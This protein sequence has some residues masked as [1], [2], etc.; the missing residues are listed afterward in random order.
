M[1][2]KTA[3]LLALAIALTIGSV[4][5]AQ[6]PSLTFTG[7]VMSVDTQ[8]HTFT[9]DT[10]KMTFTTNDQT[11]YTRNGEV[12]HLED[13]KVGDHVKVIQTGDGSPRV[14]SRVEIKSSDERAANRRLPRTGSSLPLIGLAGLV[15]LGLGVGVRQAARW[16]H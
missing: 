7:R 1:R 10:A 11:T 9:I 16:L 3:G 2:S 15:A 8:A 14:A 6:E 4:A 5:L 12:A 13:L